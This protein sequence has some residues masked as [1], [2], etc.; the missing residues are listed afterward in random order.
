MWGSSLEVQVTAFQQRFE[1]VVA[2][3]ITDELLTPPQE[4]DLPLMF[5]EIDY[6]FY[7]VLKQMAPFGTGNMKVV[8]VTDHVLAK[9]YRVLKAQHLKLHVYQQGGDRVL[10]AIGFGLAHYEALICAQKP[11][12]MVYIIEENHYLGERGLQLN[13]KDLQAM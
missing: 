13:I 4:I 5:Q 9:H 3:S 6:K 8:F 12:R 2:S 11:F 1:E 7:N 10:E